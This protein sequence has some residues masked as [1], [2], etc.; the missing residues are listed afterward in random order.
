M[1]RGV[2]ALVALTCAV[3]LASVVVADEGDPPGEVSDAVYHNCGYT[4]TWLDWIYGLFYNFGT[5]ADK[6]GHAGLYVGYFYD[7]SNKAVIHCEPQWHQTSSY[8]LLTEP[9]D[10]AEY[11]ETRAIYAEKLT[12]FTDQ[13]GDDAY[14]GAKTTR[15]VPT[16]S[17]RVTITAY[18]LEKL[19]LPISYW[20]VCENYWGSA[21]LEFQEPAESPDDFHAKGGHRDIDQIS[22]SLFLTD[23]Y[24][25]FS[26]VGFVERCYEVADLDPTSSGDEI[27]R[28]Y[29][30]WV[31]D[32]SAF[33]VP[34]QFN[35]SNMLWA[36][37][38]HP[39][40]QASVYST[41][42]NTD[43]DIT[44]SPDNYR[45]LETFQEH[46]T[47]VGS[48]S[49]THST[50]LSWNAAQY[51]LT[52]NP[53]TDF[54]YGETVTVTLGTGI[55][56][57]AGNQ[58]DGDGNGT[59]G[60]AYTK[61]FVIDLEPRKI[62]IQSSPSSVNIGIDYP[63]QT[64]RKDGATP[65]T[66]L[67]AQGT[68]ITLTAPA[69]HTGW[70][71]TEW[72]KNGQSFST[73]SSIKIQ[74]DDDA[75]YKAVYELMGS[76]LYVAGSSTPEVF[77]LSGR[78][79]QGWN[80]IQIPV[81]N[82][83]STSIDVNVT[84][85]GNAASWVQLTDG[86]SFQLSG[87][88]LKNYRIS[89]S[90]PS[91]ADPGIY[92]AY[93]SFNGIA[94]E[95]YI[96][97]S[98]STS[99][100]TF[101]F[102]N[103]SGNINGD[104]TWQEKP[105][106]PEMPVSWIDIRG[107]TT[108]NYSFTLTPEEILNVDSFRL[109]AAIKKMTQYP[110]DLLCR[111]N[112]H[113]L[114][115]FT[116]SANPQID[117][118]YH[119]IFDRRDE[120]CYLIGGNNSYTFHVNPLSS[121]DT[122]LYWQ[123]L[124]GDEPGIGF[125]RTNSVWQSEKFE[126][127]SSQWYDM[128]DKF[129][130]EVQVI[131]K[132]DSVGR[133]GS[134][135]LYVNE[136][137]PRF[138][139]INPNSNE[140]TWYLTRS[141]LL[142]YDN[143]FTIKPQTFDTEYAHVDKSG[144]GTIA[145]LSNIRL[146]MH[147]NTEIP[148]LELTKSISP[149][150][151]LAGQEA[152]VKIT[153]I[154]PT[155]YSS[156]GDSTS[157]VDAALPAGLVLTSGSLRDTSFAERLEEGDSEE[158]TYRI[159]AD[160]PGYYTLGSASFTWDNFEGDEMELESNPVVL[161]VRGGG[162]VIASGFEERKTGDDLVI[163]FFATVTA[164][165]NGAIV[166][167]AT[168][169]GSLY[170]QD[171]DDWVPFGEPVTL[172][173]DPVTGNFS[174]SSRKINRR[175]SYKA[176]LTA[177]CQFYDD[178][179]S[180]P[181]YFEADIPIWQ[182]RQFFAD[183]ETSV[184]ISNYAGDEPEIEIPAEFDGYPVISIGESAFENCATLTSISIPEGVIHIG[185]RAFAGCENLQS[186]FLP[187]TLETIGSSAFMNCTSLQ[188]ITFPNTLVSI[189]NSAFAGCSALESAVF[190]ND[191]R[192]I[193]NSAFA[194][195][196]SLES[197]VFGNGLTSLGESAFENCE[198]L[199]TVYLPDSLTTINY[200]SFAGCTALIF[201]RFGRNLE[202][203]EGEAFRNCSSLRNIFLPD[204]VLSIG[205]GAFLGCDQLHQI[206][207]LGGLSDY[208]NSFPPDAKIYYREGA[209]G[210]EDCIEEDFGVLE[211]VMLPADNSEDFEYVINRGEVTITRYKKQDFSDDN[212]IFLI[213]V[214]TQI[215][216]F[217]VVAIGEGA[218]Q[219]SMSSWWSDEWGV[220]TVI[221]PETITRIGKNAFY[222]CNL[223]VECSLP[224]GLL[225]I[226]ESAFD[227]CSNLYLSTIPQGVNIIG[228]D[229]FSGIQYLR[230]LT[231]PSG[232]L[233]IGNGAFRY[234]D[235][236]SAIMVDPANAFYSSSDDGVLFNKD[237]TELI[238]YP[239]GALQEIYSI[240]EGVVH[241]GPEAFASCNLQTVIF[242]DTVISIGDR[243]FSDCGALSDIEFGKG[244]LNIG[245]KAFAM[246][247]KLTAVILPESLLSIG[248][249]AFQGCWN[250]VTITIPD[251]VT[252]LGLGTFLWCENLQSVTLGSGITCI[253]EFVFSNCYSLS[254]ITIIP[255]TVISISENAFQ[256]CSGLSSIVL[257]EK[258]QIEGFVFCNNSQG[259]NYLRA[260]Y[261]LAEPPAIENYSFPPDAKIYYRDGSPGWDGVEYLGG[262]RVVKL[263]VGSEIPPPLA[264]NE[265]FDNAIVL[266][267]EKGQTTG[268]SARFSLGENG[269]EPG[270]EFIWWRWTAPK[271]GMVQFD[272]FLSSYDREVILAVFTGT[273][274]DSLTEIAKMQSEYDSNEGFVKPN[275]V[276]FDVEAGQEYHIAVAAGMDSTLGFTVLSWFY[277]ESFE[278]FIVAFEKNQATIVEY[279]G[280]SAAVAIPPE[281]KGVPVVAIGVAA[282]AENSSLEELLLPST[283]IRIEEGAFSWC[284]SLSEI[285]LPDGLTSIGAYAFSITGLATLTIPDSVESI[286]YGAFRW[287][288][289][290]QSVHLGS[291]LSRIEARTFSGC[292]S[293]ETLIIPANIQLISRDAFIGSG[294]A[295][296]AL[297]GPIT[298]EQCA[299][300]D[301]YEEYGN[302]Q[303]IYCL[304]A[305]PV[306][307]TFSVPPESNIYYWEGTPGWDGLTQLG[308]Q[309]VIML[310]AGSEMPEQPDVAAN[311]NFADALELNGEFGQFSGNNT[312][313]TRE[314]GEPD[315]GYASL[316]WRWTTPKSGIVQFDTL[317][318]IYD[319]V[320]GI[321][322]GNELNTLIPIAVNNDYGDVQSLVTFE[323]TAGTEYHIAVGSRWEWE[324]RGSTLLTW[325]YQESDTDYIVNFVNSQA[326]II[327][328][329]GSATEV[330]IPSEIDGCPVI[331]IGDGAFY[332]NPNITQ[333][334]IP[335]SVIRI[336]ELA[337][338]HCEKLTEVV[339]PDSLVSIGKYAFQGSGL[340]SVTIPD[341]VTSIG[342][343][344]F[345]WCWD[346][347]SV[348]FGKKL[349]SLVAE[350]FD[351]CGNLNNLFIPA[352]IQFISRNAFTWC[353]RLTS[354][355][356]E[357]IVHIDSAAFYDPIEADEEE[358]GKNYSFYCL[359][360]PPVLKT[361]SLPS[362]AVIYYHANQP[363]W[364]NVD[365]LNGHPA[366]NVQSIVN[367]V[368]FIV[369]AQG[370]HA[371]GGALR[372]E[373][374]YAQA[375]ISPEVTGTGGWLFADWDQ[376]FAQVTEPLVVF[377]QYE[378]AKYQ[379]AFDPGEHGIH[380][381]GGALLQEVEY[382]RA[383]TA[384]EITAK[385]GW[386]F[387][388][389]DQDF[390]AITGTITVKA[391]YAAIHSVTFIPGAIGWRSGGGALQQSVPEGMA[392]EAPELTVEPGWSFERW[393][394][395]FQNIT[396][397]TIIRAIYSF[398]YQLP[399]G[400][401]L[402]SVNLNLDQDSQELL[403]HKGAMTL[404]QANNTYV[405]PVQKG[406]WRSCF[407]PRGRH[408]AVQLSQ[409]GAQFPAVV[410]P[411]AT[412]AKNWAQTAFYGRDAGTPRPPR[413][414]TR[415]QPT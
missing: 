136:T 174:G 227:G 74:V 177:Q 281:I 316:W 309:P 167:N 67:Y 155:P 230:S 104:W 259:D 83:K 293:L 220:F 378:G 149:N 289:N 37:A 336:D 185:E 78:P 35:S 265:D 126:I 323:A 344:A 52:I 199:S 282:F 407:K 80:N 193:G 69:T 27:D 29:I 76:E 150:P 11:Y 314:E 134:L 349:T 356:L 382:G 288:G 6:P 385:D 208:S 113:T 285:N 213:C 264:S 410:P 114:Y 332:R 261:C 249:M 366:R 15:S 247:E 415:L 124:H 403:L 47:V 73:N 355:T 82:R 144:T 274:L 172:A 22:S 277:V 92:S 168:V 231:L 157:L 66:R 384:P 387:L 186:V 360:G 203:I 44:F 236:L 192:H 290:L 40:I 402:I 10:M 166:E 188:K 219:G 275:K 139:S 42:R 318:S 1:F 20:S 64:E 246:C 255:A 393:D 111:L 413:R 16:P 375:A 244:L 239:I 216:G 156:T 180:E 234:C 394:S 122:T 280:S 79:S 201:I 388:G 398:T 184:E 127:P 58:L 326:I 364:E 303:A 359:D 125:I 72:Q 237:K 176:V 68:W 211:V 175:G 161:E 343:G 132:V 396:G 358:D 245:T 225:V 171:G 405:D 287:C 28:L 145:S 25:A 367:T 232:L 335:D 209:P 118:M 108:F 94:Q 376:D 354:V 347:Q 392:A 257:G 339:L 128:Q 307:D 26:C 53:N 263:Q 151:V 46:V 115:T 305:P 93:V 350:T 190:G 341:S 351:G 325:F 102:R 17:Q 380:S 224:D 119:Y 120:W 352:N 197:V 372:Q 169:K 45:G 5:E 49:G 240:P 86:A 269:S 59:P 194:E 163:D 61:T 36:E 200:R 89:I 84:K 310:P 233:Y 371:G 391:L 313:C 400:W 243:A 135:R 295:S 88:E 383:A 278:D 363:G 374:G 159:K 99:E 311:D 178:A 43:I 308:G 183:G 294:V 60:P 369:G 24:N 271:D 298:I 395:E 221:L 218:F 182:T 205:S 300:Y 321:Y 85:S 7:G 408:A 162:L 41:A 117:Y 411:R 32:L 284:E 202:F 373:V 142:Q 348:I 143:V 12:Y 302:L 65:L 286:G 212:A 170:R 297:D 100:I 179:V 304:T 251:N 362:G 279:R 324:S 3:F 130:N 131:A 189:G 317:G 226:G 222:G 14:R 137:Q 207:F 147:F 331:A 48:S 214:P 412:P 33:L 262:N 370:I 229:A 173:Y 248:E 164:D 327:R 160:V 51:K 206:Y 77:A 342:F 152:T 381:G 198:N 296:I 57:L 54:S 109:S 386:Q 330:E 195:C 23:D 399:A 260:V 365:Y 252:H 215:E 87:N 272:T 121:T 154:N 256:Y 8:T 328:Y 50:T 414:L 13:S 31:V 254:T 55:K 319:T 258:V 283:I 4:P 146:Y 390:S 338:A 97:V 141:Q 315:H 56:D 238:Q 138:T 140:I 110:P 30:P 401:N 34:N 181:Y 9:G 312:G 333:V 18:A 21:N 217:P 133:A 71:F 191:L 337:F 107:N 273:G 129:L 397:D 19:D 39:K 2:K 210:W 106:L 91:S 75:T 291:G 95:F 63:D 409:N 345:R 306:L 123:V 404:D 253:E 148:N 103:S 158:H 70:L 241:I 379:V 153:I 81:Y 320:L 299:F 101:P 187:V 165:Q 223:M 204:G 96:T 301:Y 322:I 268:N 353:E 329:L 389:W 292:E 406:F 228:S 90:I 250:L 346:L 334:I 377:A 38:T 267:G 112:N 196:S 116:R 235:N 62:E 105:F 98:E 368:V 361:F 266:T 270:D 276:I 242:P 340:S 357:G